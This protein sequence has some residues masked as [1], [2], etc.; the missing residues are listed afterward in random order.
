[1]LGERYIEPDHYEDGVDESDNETLFVGYENDVS[2]TAYYPPLQDTPG[3]SNPLVF[4]SAHANS[5]NMPFCDGSVQTINYTIDLQ[6]HRYFG[7]R[8]DGQPIDPRGL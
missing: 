8:Q 4:G 2:R 1:M 5:F 3:E 7:N 6:V